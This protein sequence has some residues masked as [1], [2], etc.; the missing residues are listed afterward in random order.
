M[1]KIHELNVLTRLRTDELLSIDQV[2]E[3]VSIFLAENRQAWL[4]YGPLSDIAKRNPNSEELHAFWMSE[5]L[6]TIVPNNRIIVDLLSAYRDLFGKHDQR[7]VSQFLAHATS[8]EKWVNDEIPYQAVT[9]F[10]VNFEQLI[11][12]T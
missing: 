4:Q 9:P 1:R 5:K 12:G 8:Y 10:P 2:K 11:T 3:R 7:V 6:S